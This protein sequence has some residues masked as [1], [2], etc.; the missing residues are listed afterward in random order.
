MD[1]AYN[2]LVKNGVKEDNIRVV[3]VPG[4]FELPS[5]AQMVLEAKRDLRYTQKSVKEIAI[6]LGFEDPAYF[7][8][9]FKKSE[10]ESPQAYRMAYLKGEE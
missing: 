3:R 7:T 10:N 2:T 1:G 9:Y 5:G 4:S 6:D 8:R